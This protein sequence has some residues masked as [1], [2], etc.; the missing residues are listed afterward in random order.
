M[1]SRDDCDL[2][3]CISFPDGEANDGIHWD[4]RGC[5][6]RYI[7]G[8]NVAGKTALDVGTASG[9]LAFTA[10]QNGRCVSPR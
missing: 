1:P 9:F 5:F 4:L 10:E 7:G 3:H 8:I 6:E 2:Y